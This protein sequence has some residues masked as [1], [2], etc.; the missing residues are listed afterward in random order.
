MGQNNSNVPRKREE[1]SEKESS[2]KRKSQIIRGSF[3]IIQ[4]R[5]LSRA[6][7]APRGS[8]TKTSGGNAQIWTKIHNHG[9]NCQFSH[10][11]WTSSRPTGKLSSPLFIFLIFVGWFH[12]MWYA[13]RAGMHARQRIIRCH[14]NYGR[15]RWILRMRVPFKGIICN[16]VYAW[17]DVKI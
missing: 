3:L 15:M 4:F 6:E 1:S 14:Q 12:F 9:G 5:F 11:V 16:L 8:P 10:H 13:I 17:S 2:E 7:L